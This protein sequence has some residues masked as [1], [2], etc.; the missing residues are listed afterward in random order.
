MLFL[1][2]KFSK[3]ELNSDRKVGSVCCP[4]IKVKN[5][6]G[7]GDTFSS[8]FFGEISKNSSIE[9][10]LKKAVAAG[11]LSSKGISLNKIKNY[12]IILNQFSKKVIVIKKM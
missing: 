2:W 11:C 12:K 5:E 10:A 7:A 4:K 9:E 8:I 6:N 3:K 1:F